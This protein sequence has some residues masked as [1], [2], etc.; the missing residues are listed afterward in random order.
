MGMH[1]VLVVDDSKT[2]L[3]NL[4]GILSAAGCVVLTST[5][6]QDA[7]AKAKAERPELIF[8]DIIMPEM[9]GY[10]AC[11]KLGEDASTK[12]IPVVFVTSKNQ[13]A[14]RVWA[15]MQGAKDLVTKPYT[16]ADILPHLGPDFAPGPAAAAKTSTPEPDASADARDYML[17]MLQTFTNP[18][19]VRRLREAIAAAADGPALE[20]QADAWHAAIAESPNGIA[21]VDRL[22]KKLHAMLRP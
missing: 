16:D 22:R 6:A 13:K 8:L 5:N 21:E 11:R 12:D 3:T 9:D 19:R 2:D 14:D 15:L 1:K 7:I 17:A 4:E 18:V 10:E 20:A